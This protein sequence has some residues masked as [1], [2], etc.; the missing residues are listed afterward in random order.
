MSYAFCTSSQWAMRF[1]GTP[2]WAMRFVASSQWAMHFDTSLQLVL[3]AVS[4]ELCSLLYEVDHSS[5]GVSS[6]GSEPASISVSNK[7][8]T[9]ISQ[10][11]IAF[12][13]WK[14][15]TGQSCFLVVCNVTV[16]QLGMDNCTQ[17]RNSQYPENWVK[18]FHPFCNSALPAITCVNI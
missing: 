5:L 4:H 14:Q 7:A 6:E 12:M 10:L 15:T 2:Q 17:A 18:V 16:L 13:V 9:Y 3:F 8:P 11:L 1:V